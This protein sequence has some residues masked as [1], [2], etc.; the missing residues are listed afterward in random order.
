MASD[1][2]LAA[3]WFL[4]ADQQGATSATAELNLTIAGPAATVPSNANNCTVETAFTTDNRTIVPID[5]IKD[6]GKYRCKE[7]LSQ[8]RETIV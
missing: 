6:G 2:L 5:S 1:N 4:T 7:S 8:E 3:R